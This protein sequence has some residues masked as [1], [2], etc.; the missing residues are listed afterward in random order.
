MTPGGTDRLVCYCFGWS[1]AELLAEAAVPKPSAIQ[2]S[3]L[4]ACR[5]GDADCERKNPSGG[6]CLGEVARVLK[7]ARGSGSDCSG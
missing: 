7:Q 3:I 1:E 5:A 4:K 6:C 2:A